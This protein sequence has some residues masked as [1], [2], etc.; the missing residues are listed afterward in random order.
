MCGFGLF[1]IK[2]M[3]EIDIT[4][5]TDSILKYLYI[6]SHFFCMECIRR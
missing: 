2:W 1:F 3:N 5:Y 6:I 4:V